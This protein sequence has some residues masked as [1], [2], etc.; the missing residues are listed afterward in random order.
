M[1]ASPLVLPSGRFRR[2]ATPRS[3][4]S[5]A[6]LSLALAFAL[7]LGLTAAEK[8]GSG[9]GKARAEAEAEAAP[10][11][12]VFVNAVAAKGRAFLVIDDQDANPEGFDEGAAT[13]WV[14]FPSGEQSILVEHE[15]LGRVLWKEKL[16]PGSRHVL[17][18]HEEEVASERPGRP[19]RPGLGLLR[20]Q[21]GDGA[22]AQ[23][24]AMRSVVVV[25]TGPRESVSLQV[26]DDTVEARRLQPQRV[27]AASGFLTVQGPAAP[28]PEGTTAPVELA[29]LNLEEP[30]GVF[31][32]VFERDDGALGAAMVRE[33][34]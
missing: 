11:S 5:V 34:Q 15:P 2:F 10:A 14:N 26:G 13:G 28:A 31:V 24:G 6:L 19:K 20:L 27:M 25:Y 18:A 30:G 8:K 1:N 33:G 22:T 4:R 7:P 29:V 16:A 17:V 32:I 9:T 3:W 21:A 23:E 12:V